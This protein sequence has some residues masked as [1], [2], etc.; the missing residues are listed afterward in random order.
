MNIRKRSGKL[1]KLNIDNI[2]EQTIDATKGLDA[3]YET[4][5]LNASLSFVDGMKSSEIQHLLIKSALG[6]VDVDKPDYV[7]VAGRLKLYD[8]YHQVK[9][10]YGK[11]KS[12]TKEDI[13]KIITLK[14]YLEFCK[15]ILSYSSKYNRFDIERLEKEINSSRDL[16]FTYNAID[17]FSSRYMLKKKKNIVE[18]PQHAFM[19][20]AMFIAQDEEN[21]TDK[22]I[23]FYNVMSKLEALMATP[24]LANGRTLEGN[25]FSCA[26]GSM[27]DDLEGIFDS[28][29]EIGLG[30]KFGT[31]WGYDVTRI[32]A[33]GGQIRGI[34]DASNGIVPPMKIMNDISIYVDQ[35]G[36]RLGAIAVSIESWHK[37]IID[38]LDLKK[39]NGDER[40]RAKELFIAVSCS[41]LFMNRVEKNE[42][43][44]LFDPYDVPELTETFSKEFE[45]IYTKYENDFLN[46]K[47]FTNTPVRINAKDLWK[48]IQ[49]MYF[50]TGM[51]FLFFKD[52]VNKVHENKEEGIIRSSN[53]CTEIFQPTNSDK[54]ILCNL[55]SLN[56]SKVYTKEDL[57]RV[58]P[59]VCR[60]L[61][62]VI[63]LS[64]YPIP[65]TEEVQKRTRAVGLGVAGEGELIANKQ[66]IYG[67]K[68]HLEFIDELYA[69]IEYYSDKTSKELAVER[70]PWKEGEEHRNAYRRAL[71]PTSSISVIMGTTAMH[72]G[73]FDKVWIEE[74]KMG[75]VK[76]IAP[77]IN[78]DN[79][80]FY[81][82]PYDVNQ[83]DA[84][85]CTAIRQKYTDQGISHNIYFRPEKTNGK[86]V[87]DTLMLA[88][89]L[90]LKSTYYLRSESKKVTKEP[91][92]K[93]SKIACVGCEN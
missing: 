75:N 29:K 63:D 14:D 12:K 65:G 91:T 46:G 74:T 54:T 19:S 5:E 92:V 78:P 66:I 38:Y 43:F 68:E 35:L 64:T 27:P 40:R 8:I 93:T 15:D 20:I 90:G 22:A 80:A 81:V 6:L 88:W 76:M 86:E 73:A 69:N 51:P 7:F 47:E 30:S 3:S 84:I 72:E 31:G 33:L 87:F 24:T 60:M 2:R 56:L 62:N 37:D 17:T 32:R 25:C 21:P 18:L 48:K 52:N 41:D 71:A 57:E 77:N 16:L 83:Q 34:P 23:E 58:V 28:F 67:S 26:V 45:D 59:I 89:K 70:G 53:L 4:L 82:S 50:E 13:Y 11:T 39:N 42:M 49:K 61:D 85:K 79:F 44:T 55:A 36:V 1:E 10:T 9:R